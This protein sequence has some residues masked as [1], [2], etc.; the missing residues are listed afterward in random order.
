MNRG[1]SARSRGTRKLHDRAACA[2]RPV[3]DV[4]STVDNEGS[5]AA[6]TKA[7]FVGQGRFER[8]PARALTGAP[9]GTGAPPLA[10]TRLKRKGR[11]VLGRYE[12][13]G[14]LARG[15]MGTVYLAR[16]AGEAGFQRL[17][18]V[19]VMHAHLAAETAFVDM[20]RDE[21][22]IAARIHHPNVVAIVDLGGR[23]GPALR[24][25]GVRR[26]TGVREATQ[27]RH[28]PQHGRAGR[29]RGDRCAR[30]IARGA[31]AQ[32]RRRRTSCIWC[33]ATFPR[34]TSWSA[35]TESGA[36]PISALR[37]RRRGSRALS[38]ACARASSRSCRRSR[39]R[40][41]TTSTCG[42]ISGRPAWC[43]GPR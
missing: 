15:G 30:G 29:R 8:R 16:H 33:T 6:A 41:E 9:D 20:L 28:R 40:T 39:S 43:S 21:A 11:R 26:G 42:P 38:P 13:I 25:D 32:E 23:R 3:A 2:R 18:A 4:R 12:L 31:H 5:D 1:R 27:A 35:S 37:K 14:E 10:A 22:R 17:F 7:A 19:K 36:S 24:R 34:K